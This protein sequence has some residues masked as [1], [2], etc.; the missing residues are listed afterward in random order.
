MEAAGNA[1]GTVHKPVTALD[2][3]QQAHDEQQ[4]RYKHIF[5]L[6]DR[7]LA[8]L[9]ERESLSRAKKKRLL[10]QGTHTTSL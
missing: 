4:N 2:Q 3:A 8:R 5:L 7:S 10:L 9:Q 1:G 6:F